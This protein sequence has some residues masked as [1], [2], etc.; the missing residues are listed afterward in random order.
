MHEALTQAFH[1]F[2]SELLGFIRKRLPDSS[3]AEDLLHELFLRLERYPSD[4]VIKAPRAYLYRA[5]NNLIVDEL[6]KKK[7]YDQRF[8]AAEQE[9]APVHISPE[10]INHHQQRLK[11]LDK[12]I[13]E[14]PEK[15]QKAF[16]WHR[17]EQ[18]DKKIIAERLEVSVNM[19][20]KHLRNAVKHCQQRLSEAEETTF[21]DSHS[22]KSSQQRHHQ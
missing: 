14:L 10:D 1:Q 22:S 17:I 9:E 12:A 11:L 4:K 7:S 3:Q 21:S 6:R 19:V 16:R 15:C 2:Q 20:E 13:N 18:L 8:V 5:A